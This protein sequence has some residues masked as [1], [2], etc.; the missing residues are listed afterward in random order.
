MK[1]LLLQVIL[2]FLVGC[3]HAQSLAHQRC[4]AFGRGQNM[5]NWLEAS[6][7]AGWPA[8]NGYSKRDLQDMKEAGSQS[9]RLPVVFAKVTDTLPPYDVDLN[10]PVFQRIDSVISWCDELQLN[11]IIDNHHEWKLTNQNWRSQIVRF[12]NMW[13]MIAER[14]NYLDPEHYFFE[15][16][17]EPAIGFDLDS[18]DILFIAAIDSIRKHAPHH[19]IIASPHNGS[20]GMS[21]YY[22]SPLPDT[23]LIYTWHTYDPLNFTHQGLTW[24]TPYFPQGT[25]FPDS[26]NLFEQFLHDGIR[27]VIHWRDSFGKPVF[28]GE[29]GVGKYADAESRCNWIEFIGSVVLQHDIPWFYWDWRY[30]FPMFYSGVPAEDSIIP[31]FRRALGL[32]GDTSFTFVKHEPPG[33]LNVTLRPTLVAAGGICQIIIQ[34][35]SHFQVTIAD[36]TG[37][38]IRQLKLYGAR[39][40]M[41]MDFEKGIYCVSVTNGRASAVRT[42]MVY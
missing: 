13:G 34:G 38:T 27:E 8:S 26:N 11:L 22:Y 15:L 30:D 4:I 18:L 6:W 39:N 29:F 23:N 35:E 12:S 40:E 21:Y 16:L 1:N 2:L 7:Q 10:H 41:L 17:N 25:V 14:Y 24:H 42:V 20:W 37:R 31:C 36:A 32:Y 33:T 3:A 19:T 9:V 28:L 5:S